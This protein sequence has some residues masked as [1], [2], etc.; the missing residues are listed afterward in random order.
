MGRHAENAADGDDPGAANPGD[1]DVVGLGDR[2]QLGVGQRGERLRAGNT[3][4]ALEL[5][6]VHSDK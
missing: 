5:G 3:R 1:D 2:R 6:P 4:A